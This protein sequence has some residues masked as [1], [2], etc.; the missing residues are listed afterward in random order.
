[1]IEKNSNTY[2]ALWVGL[3][4]LSSF[5]V[6]IVSAA[7][8]SR[9]FDKA[10]YGTYRQ[11]LY[12]YNTLL[13]V[14]TA[15][16]PRV[17][18]Y[19]LPRYSLG[20]GKEIVLKIT[21]TLFLFG[22][23]FSAF[24]LIFSGTI[25]KILN[26]SDLA[27]GLKYFSPIPMLL[28]PTLGI[29][30]IFSTYKKTVYIAIYNTLSRLLMLI[31][32]VLPVILFNGTYLSAIYGWLIAS[33]VTLFIAF[34]FKGIPFRNVIIE[35]ATLSM[36]QVFSYSIPLV[37]ASLAGIAIRSADQFYISRYFG[38]DVFAE[39]ANGFIQLP[40]VTMITS[41]TSMVLMPQFSKIVHEKADIKQIETLWRSALVKSA[42]IIYPIII[43][44]V[45]HAKEIIYILY[46][47]TYSNSI[48]YLQ[49][50][51]V[52]NFFNIIIFAPLLFSLGETRYYFKLH[53]FSA[54][55]VWLGGYLVIS[56]KPIPEYIAILS[57]SVTIF[58]VFFN[59]KKISR[60]L[61]LSFGNLIPYK[62]LSLIISH[63]L[64][65]VILIHVGRKFVWSTFNEVSTIITNFVFFISLLL[66]SSKLFKIDYLSTIRPL[67]KKNDIT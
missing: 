36:R 49:I 8:L 27:T 35:K 23:M 1:M 32:I 6:G 21:K 63:S 14:F 33:V 44:F 28:L 47:D 52:I 19:F 42:V 20:Q 12:V 26:N 51:M 56:L 13:T 65:I 55:I 29:E 22:L 39:Y 67:L 48:V 9:Y 45:F 61:N 34:Y 50:A 37:G 17:F 3:G 30:G 58:M 66:L 57:A 54:A 16:L 31:F 10:E 59:V 25:A 41:A 38:A 24:L 40:F 7:I 43:F 11:I 60:L 46:T 53:L 5:A 64:L 2:Q 15:G 4:S 62:N 18:S